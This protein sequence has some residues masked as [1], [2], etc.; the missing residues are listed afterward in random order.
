[1]IDMISI[2]MSPIVRPKAKTDI[3]PFSSFLTR[4]QSS[5]I[6]EE[7]DGGYDSTLSTSPP[8]NTI[9]TPMY[10]NNNST[11][12]NNSTQQFEEDGQYQNPEENNTNNA[13]QLDNN[14]NTNNNNEFPTDQVVLCDRCQQFAATLECVECGLPYCEECWNEVHS[15]TIFHSVYVIIYSFIYPNVLLL[16]L[17]LYYYYYYQLSLSLHSGIVCQTYSLSHGRTNRYQSRI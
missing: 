15:G 1:M 10:D 13:Q 11:N 2:Q 14:N 6:I 8:T 5:L 4:K 3:S 7:S 12:G 16:I 9:S 17:I